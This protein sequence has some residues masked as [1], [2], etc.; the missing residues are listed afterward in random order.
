MKSSHGSIYVY[1]HKFCTV[2]KSCPYLDVFARLFVTYHDHF[3]LH[4]KNMGG[5]SSSP[6]YDVVGYARLGAATLDDF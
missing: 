4:L 1:I 2:P 3:F 6:W 5:W